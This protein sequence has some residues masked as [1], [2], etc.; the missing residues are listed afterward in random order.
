MITK[1]NAVLRFFLSI[2]FLAFSQYL[3]GEEILRVWYQDML[4]E[5]G[6]R[7]LWHQPYANSID[8]W[9]VVSNNP[10]Q[11]ATDCPNQPM[12]GAG[13]TY[14]SMVTELGTRVH[15]NSPRLYFPYST[16]KAYLTLE[17]LQ[18]LAK[19]K[20]R[21]QV[22]IAGSHLNCPVMPA[23]VRF[24]ILVQATCKSSLNIDDLKAGNVFKK[25]Y[26]SDWQG[27]D[28]GVFDFTSYLNIDTNYCD[29]PLAITAR[30][31]PDQ[32][33]VSLNIVE[34]SLYQIQ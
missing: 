1:S 32:W 30:I 27:T 22:R 17:E 4:A 9:R 5:G 14:H 3:H 18:G 23:G 20:T 25:S 6:I 21:L 28:S 2:W 31:E 19:G 13:R 16:T 12:D 26:D 15:A 10:F 34:V 33:N 11:A 24:S 29:S 8:T 7:D